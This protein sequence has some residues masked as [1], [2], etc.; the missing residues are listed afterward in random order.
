MLGFCFVLYAKGLENLP[1]MMGKKTK[2]HQLKNILC[3]FL[4]DT[5][6]SEICYG[7]YLPLFS[8][9]KVHLIQCST[10]SSKPFGINLKNTL[11]S[12]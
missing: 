5:C 1:T 7:V 2:H 9:Q 8:G 10:Y 4:V 12:T 3:R 6:G 11:S